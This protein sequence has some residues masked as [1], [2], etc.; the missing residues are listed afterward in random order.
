MGRSGWGRMSRL[1]SHEER[2]P[3]RKQRKGRGDHVTGVS[4]TLDLAVMAEDDVLGK[5]ATGVKGEEQM[6]SVWEEEGR[7]SRCG[8]SRGMCK[9]AP[10][11]MAE[12]AMFL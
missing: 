1:G 10:S 8:G 5:E 11:T 3:H 9:R 2:G 12:E 4:I 7:G 6:K